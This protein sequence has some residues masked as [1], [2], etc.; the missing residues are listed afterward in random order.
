M[1]NIAL[2]AGS[3]R[4]GSQSAKVARYLR[5]RLIELGLT[6]LEQSHMIDL[7]ERGL[8]LWPADDKGP[9][10]EYQQQLAAAD[11][12]VVIA[13]E[14]NGMA[15][16]A[17]KNFFLYASKTE[18]AHKPALLVGVSSGIGGAY[19]ISELRASGYKNCR[20]AYL[21]EHLIVRQVEA[22]MNPGEANGEDDLRIRN[23]ADYAL[24]ILG[25]YAE[26]LKP[27]RAA[28]DLNNP[29]FTNGM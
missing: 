4:N 24:D 19:P 1:L 22:V 7:G 6:S 14:W 27:V 8:P 5:Q 28:I 2:I 29:A 18:L 26:A 10:A 3:S 20:I 15:C 21:P 23:R 16:P 9:W 13:P 25:K 12:L 11:A 17:V